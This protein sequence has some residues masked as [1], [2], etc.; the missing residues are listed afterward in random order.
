MK[1]KKSYVS[2]ITLLAALALVMASAWSVRI[3]LAYFTTYATAKGSHELALG[4]QTTLHEDIK[5]MEKH[6]RIENTGG[7][8][9]YVRV[10]VFAGSTVKLSFAG[11]GWKQEADGYW[12]YG[13]IVAPGASANTMVVSITGPED[14]DMETFN[15]V[16]VQECTPVLYNEAGEP[17]ADWALSL[18]TAGKEAAQ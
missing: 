6:V 4:T 11:D 10:K 13:N 15:V 2:K 12:Y 17:Y 7:I 3:S 5:G 1:R 14:E 18:D 9:C 16:V 8:D